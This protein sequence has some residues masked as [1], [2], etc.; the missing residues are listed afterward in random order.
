MKFSVVVPLYNKAP[1]IELTLQ[2]V[3]AQSLG[4]FEVV[5]VD[6]GSTDASPEIVRKMAGNES[7]IRL[8][9]QRNSGVSIARNAGITAST[10]EWIAFLDAD[11][12][13]H[14]DHLAQLARAVDTY[15]DV[16]MVA[17]GLRRIPDV[18]DWNPVSWPSLEAHPKVSLIQ[19]LPTRWMQGI[20]F[21]TSSVA[22]RRRRLIELQPCFPL[23]ESHGEDLD[24]WFR[25][26]EL[27]DIAHVQV[28]TVAYRTA[29]TGSLTVSH[30]NRAL[31]PFLLRLEGRA[32]SGESANRRSVS[33]LNFVA[34][35]KVTFARLALMD[36]KR[37][38]GLRW[39]WTAR[40]VA[41]TKRWLLSV[42]M[43]VLVPSAGIQRWEHW[44]QAR[45]LCD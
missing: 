42:L 5:I 7:R 32:R 23:G 19:D 4:D 18:P 26:A 10:G 9:E 36:G 6:D 13:W 30:G 28:A 15:A 43:L 45:K 41:L 27:S 44:R 25:V 40:G 24:L 33:T 20:P 2:S 8:L 1:Y 16:D 22:I 35:Q 3:L 12:W 17:S 38:E 14:P 29:V 21:F 39:L 37:L 34:Q 31:A 11:D